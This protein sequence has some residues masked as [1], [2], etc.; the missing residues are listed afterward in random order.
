MRT[1]EFEILPVL[2]LFTVCIF[3]V[4][5]VLPGFIFIILLIAGGVC[6]TIGQKVQSTGFQLAGRGLSGA[7]GLIV[8]ICAMPNINFAKLFP[9]IR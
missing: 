1:I 4:S 6:S 8:L 5:L 7:S 9:Y 2:L 3:T